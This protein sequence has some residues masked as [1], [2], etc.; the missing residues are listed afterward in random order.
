MRKTEPMADGAGTEG[1]GSGGSGAGIDPG[2]PW[3]RALAEP[4]PFRPDP[5]CVTCTPP[6][7]DPDVVAFTDHWKV[8]L[9]PD[10]TVAG[11]CL[12]GSRRHVAKVGELTTDEAAD[13]FRLYATLEPVLE[14]VIGADLVNLSC[15][16]N[17]AYR[18]VDPE[19]PWSD[20]RPNPHV[21][22]HVA[23]RY[24][25]PVDI[26]GEAIVDVDFGEE[27]VWTGRRLPPPVRTH[28]ITTLRAALPITFVPPAP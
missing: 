19:P 20:G 10:Q 7:A 16:R 21:H 2:G 3:L 1:P 24:R 15:L 26:A 14:R 27:L 11:A 25:D 4:V 6:Q 13:L 5:R 12:L 18:E 28:L 17:W 8:V 22:W 9:H 23:P